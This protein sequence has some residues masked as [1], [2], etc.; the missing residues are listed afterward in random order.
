M[1]RQY[2]VLFPLNRAEAEYRRNKA[3][4]LRIETVPRI[5]VYV[6]IEINLPNRPVIPSFKAHNDRLFSVELD[7]KVCGELS[8]YLRLDLV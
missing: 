6:L 4:N 5:I 7:E 3:V 8:N 1:C 2:F